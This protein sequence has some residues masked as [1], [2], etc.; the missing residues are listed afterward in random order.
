MY[1]PTPAIVTLRY[2]TNTIS[3]FNEHDGN[4]EILGI[5]IYRDLENIL[6][7][8]QAA[9][10][11]TI[12]AINMNNKRHLTDIPTP[13]EKEHLA[14][15]TH[16]YMPTQTDDRWPS[17]LYGTQGGI[18]DMLE[19]GYSVYRE[20]LPPL[21]IMAF[22]YELDFYA[23]TITVTIPNGDKATYP[24]SK[25]VDIYDAW[26]SG[27]LWRQTDH[28]ELLAYQAPSPDNENYDEH[29]PHAACHCLHH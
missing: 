22:H 18:R 6:N 28:D 21:H 4:L 7:G 15:Y 14:P 17:L 25:L 8:G 19:A 26:H 10:E 23:E 13:A 11:Q 16:I 20:D 24:F 12:Y 9:L 2:K 1:V 5:R 27:L 3:C 29:P